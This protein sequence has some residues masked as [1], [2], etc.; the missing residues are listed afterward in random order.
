V[1]VFNNNASVGM[2]HKKKIGQDA[3]RTRGRVG[4]CELLKWTTEV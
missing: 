2:L 1:G 3:H 4:G